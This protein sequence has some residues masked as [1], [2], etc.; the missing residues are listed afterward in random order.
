[1]PEQI[2]LHYPHKNFQLNN[3]TMSFPLNP[4][5]GQTFTDSGIVYTWHPE[6]RYWLPPGLEV[7][8]DVNKYMTVPVEGIIRARK[9]IPI[10][11]S[12]IDREWTYV[13][14]ERSRRFD[15]IQWRY[16]RWE[17]E[18]R[19]GMTTTDTISVLDA[20]AQALA[21]IPQTQVDPLNIVWP[22]LDA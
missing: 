7:P 1:M 14:S 15:D 22:S 2:L 3:N 19:L 21:D 13:K 8:F 20:Y 5:P 9:V 18:T 11:S 16:Q 12:E 4:L 6:S 17:R 10:Q